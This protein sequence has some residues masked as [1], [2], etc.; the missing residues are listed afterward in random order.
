VPEP[1]RVAVGPPR[2]VAAN[3]VVTVLPAIS[4]PAARSVSTQAASMLAREWA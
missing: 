1:E 4:A 2:L 3:S